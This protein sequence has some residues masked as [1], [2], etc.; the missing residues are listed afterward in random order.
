MLRAG[1]SPEHFG[2]IH[3]DLEPPNWLFHRG[4]A[5][6]IDFDEFGLGF[7]AF[8][9]MQIIWTH[10]LWP[11]YATFRQTL[12]EGYESIRPISLPVRSHLDLFQAIPFFW[13]L[14]KGLDG[15][16][17]TGFRRWLTPTI[18]ILRKLCGVK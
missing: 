15:R 1:S 10:A 12:L 5:R 16:A 8:D 13:W 17:G 11:D 7:F 2:L 18:E 3:A 6:P 14:N 9:L 4:E